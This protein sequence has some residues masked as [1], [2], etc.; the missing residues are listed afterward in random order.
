M[1]DN[2]FDISSAAKKALHTPLEQ[3]PLPCRSQPRSTWR[4]T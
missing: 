2:V 3:A 1:N 4:T